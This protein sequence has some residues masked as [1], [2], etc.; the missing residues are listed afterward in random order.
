MYKWTHT[1]QTHVVQGPLHLQSNI[2]T[3][4]LRRGSGSNGTFLTV[5]LPVRYSQS[6]P[7]RRRVKTGMGVGRCELFFLKALP[8]WGVLHC[9][10]GYLLSARR[11][12]R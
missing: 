11:R 12:T 5:S 6:L 9:A 7:Q 3:V 2:E 8:R 4:V 1:V 10:L